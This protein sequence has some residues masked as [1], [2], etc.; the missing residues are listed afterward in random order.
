M[1]GCINHSLRF[2][3]VGAVRTDTERG[4]AQLQ[5]GV[6]L[7]RPW[8]CCRLIADTANDEAIR[9]KTPGPSLNAAEPSPAVHNG[10]CRG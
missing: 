3:W 9:N 8:N 10:A 6:H 5:F 1:T 7:I 4:F 2:G